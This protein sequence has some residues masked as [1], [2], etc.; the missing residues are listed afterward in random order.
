MRMQHLY[1]WIVWLGN[2]RA[3]IHHSQSGLLIVQANSDWGSDCI[4]ESCIYGV[5]SLHA[6]VMFLKKNW[7]DFHRF[8]FLFEDLSSDKISFT[9]RGFF[10]LNKSF[11][12][13]HSSTN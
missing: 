7:K 3:A 4:L 9:L 12:E 5:P 10:F 13:I 6:I 1:T 8:S 2:E 11:L